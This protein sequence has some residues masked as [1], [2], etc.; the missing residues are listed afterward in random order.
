MTKGLINSIETLGT[1]DGPGIRFVVFLQGCRLRCLYCHNPETWDMKGESVE[2]TSQELVE[3][4][5]KYKN[6]YG[7]DGGVTFSGG[8][9]LLQPEFLV[10]CLK[11]CKEKNIHTCLDTAGFG[12]GDYDEILKYT[13]L[14]ILDIKAVEEQE[15]KNITGQKMQKFFEFLETAQK[16][17]KKLW[18]RQVIVPSINDDKKHVLKLKE[19]AK[20]IKNLGITMVEFL[21]LNEF[22]SKQNGVNHW[23]YMPLG[24]F[25]LARKYAYDKKAGNLLNEF[26]ELIT[27]FH[28]NKD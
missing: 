22:D 13:D 5:E 19:F 18:L 28:K 11:M 3:K 20:T 10:E 15:Y 6:Y 1:L 9:P 21:P 27:E 12:F 24:Y 16:H 8:E 2:I 14:V 17:N 7:E 4:V 23:G 25:S 26:R